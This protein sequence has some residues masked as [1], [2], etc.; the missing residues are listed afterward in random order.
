M[1]QFTFEQYQAATAK[2][3][4][5]G[6]G[7]N[8]NKIGFFKLA[9]EGAEA[10]V[11]FDVSTINDLHFAT[12]HKPVFGKKFESKDHPWA[13][14]SCCN[15][16]GQTT[17]SCPLCQMAEQP[18]SIVSR[19][20]KTVYVKMLVAYKDPTTGGYSAPQPVIWE[21]PAGFA[22]EISAKLQTYG[23][24]KEILMKITRTGSGTDTRYI[25]DYAPEK[26]Y[27]P[28][29][30]PADFSAF[31]NFQINKHSYWEKSADEIK[32]FLATGDFPSNSVNDKV[33]P[34]IKS[35]SATPAAQAYSQPTAADFAAHAAP[36]QVFNG[37]AQPQ[38]MPT[39]Q[40]QP[41]AQPAPVAQ[42]AQESP[43]PAAAKP[44]TGFS[45]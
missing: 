10:L 15:P 38:V 18:D 44:F 32:A 21:R 39:A 30:I 9:N 36:Q 22:K 23:S 45:F 31:E 24:L 19:A 29:M 8:S 37:M 34:A 20:K 17:G 3:A 4:T 16:F 26:I 13:V 43:K 14:I 42:P 11:R 2:A 40:P 28:E 27:K 41:A 6:D 12:V 33:A 35:A 1:A 25:M 7:T 5:G